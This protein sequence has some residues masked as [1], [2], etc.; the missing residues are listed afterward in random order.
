MTACERPVRWSLEPEMTAW[1]LAHD[2]G[3]PI[4][5][6]TKDF[7]REFGFTLTKN[8]VSLFRSSHETQSRR[9]HGGGKPRKPVGYERES[10]GYI[11]V[12]IAEEATVPQS[13]DNWR[14][15][16]V[17][18]W[19]QAHGQALPKGWTVLFLD[20][21][22]RN[23]DLENLYAIPRTYIAQINLKVSQGIKYH[24]RESFEAI[25]A[26]CKLDTAILDARNR[27][28]KCALCGSEFIPDSV[29]RHVKQLTCRACLDS[30]HKS[31]WVDRSPSGEGVCEVCG[32]R[33]PRFFS[34]QK[35]CSSCTTARY[36]R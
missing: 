23:F 6:V 33:F 36:K 22:R 16:H 31:T 25:L 2:C 19:G 29:N 11:L 27:P 34:H 15:K 14:M 28:R 3:R 20:G 13:K 12:K 30:G 32:T 18:L 24:D 1:M 5:E 35:R 7:R 4:P 8:Q 9:S 26:V 21:D 17:W 10:K